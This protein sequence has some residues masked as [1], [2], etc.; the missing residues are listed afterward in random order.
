MVYKVWGLGLQLQEFGLGIEEFGFT[1][2]GVGN[3]VQV[4]GSRVSGV[5][6]RFSYCSGHVV[7]SCS[8]M[9]RFSCLVSLRLRGQQ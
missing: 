1:W 3:N 5:G 2:Q 4:L 7:Y 6:L 8:F 9:A